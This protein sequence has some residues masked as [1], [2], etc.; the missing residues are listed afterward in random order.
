MGLRST[1]KAEPDQKHGFHQFLKFSLETYKYVKLHKH[2][3]SIPDWNL[4][5][6][7]PG[8]KRNKQLIR[9]SK[10]YIKT[11]KAW[12]LALNMKKASESIQVH[13]SATSVKWN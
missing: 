4:Q 5:S 7:L 2:L 12:M 11:K 3:P 6:V 10:F 13:T 8:G 9:Q 1:W